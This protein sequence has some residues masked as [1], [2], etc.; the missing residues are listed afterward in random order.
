[1]RWRITFRWFRNRALEARVAGLEVGRAGDDAVPCVS[2]IHKS[3]KRIPVIKRVSYRLPLSLAIGLISLAASCGGKSSSPAG[4]PANESAPQQQT[5]AA[6]N[7]AVTGAPANASSKWTGDLDGMIN[8][9]VIRVLT[10]YSK[11]NYFVDQ[12]TQ[13][14]LI[15]DA[16]LQ[17]ERT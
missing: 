9:R 16:F 4:A 12:A 8:R 10:T 14:G 3:R 7:P 17:F 13:R 2:T 5:P 11:V 1:M 6:A 15:Y